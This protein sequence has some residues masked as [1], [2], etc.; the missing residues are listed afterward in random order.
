VLLAL[1]TGL[2][3]RVPIDKVIEAE[4]ALHQGI[5]S[6]PADLVNRLT[7]AEKLS[8]AD[9]QAILDL[10]TRTLLPFQPAPQTKTEPKSE[11]TPEAKSD[12]KPA[13]NPAGEAKP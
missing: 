7:S 11:S 3:D 9:R 5:A 1:T 4:K 8:D 12:A 10:A 6:I 13:P 2:F